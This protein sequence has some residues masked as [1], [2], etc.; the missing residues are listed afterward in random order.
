M[1]YV[2][3][4]KGVRA[5][6]RLVRGGSNV[7]APTYESAA[8]SPDDFPPPFTVRWATTATTD[9]TSGWIIWLPHA[10]LVLWDTDPLDI[11]TGMSAATNYPTGWYLL[12][13]RLDPATGGTLWLNITP[14]V[15]TTPVQAVLSRNASTTTGVISIPICTATR[16]ASTGEVFV[17]QY[18]DST[19]ALASGSG[20]GGGGGLSG[21]VEFI[22]DADWYVNGSVHVL[23][24]RL[25]ILDLA[26]GAVT[27][28][29][30]TTYGNGW[31]LLANTT[32][33]SG[34]INGGS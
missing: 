29:P 1:A 4:A 3:S 19:L 13:T 27:D 12:A 26:T 17:K 20:S 34:I 23:R 31:E 11:T 30:G 16:D 25:R 7:T 2:L 10:S 24:K 5:L 33:I 32:P 8:V 18:V 14:P 22:A 9:G 28:K 21:T 15:A 6:S